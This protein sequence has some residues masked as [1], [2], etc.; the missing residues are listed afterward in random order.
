MRDKIIKQFTL[1]ILHAI[2]ASVL[3]SLVCYFYAT[4]YFGLLVDFSEGASVWPLLGRY[5]ILT[6]ILTLPL[7][8]IYQFV[9]CSFLKKSRFSE[10]LM[11]L[12]F[13][14]LTVALVFYVLKMKEPT[15]KKEDTLLFVD[16]FKGFLMPM[17]FFPLLSWFTLKPLF[18]S[19]KQAH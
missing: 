2:C 12:V 16:F 5:F 9:I 7:S 13:S 1:S 17:L 14:G 18:S 15:F 11:G 6:G 3:A 8:I 19:K 10:M 4:F